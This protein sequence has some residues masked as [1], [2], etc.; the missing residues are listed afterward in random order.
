LDDFRLGFSLGNP[1]LQ[2][3]NRSVKVSR[4]ISLARDLA[5]HKKQIFVA[6]VSVNLYP[7]PVKPERGSERDSL[8][9]RHSVFAG[10]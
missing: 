8:K 3:A 4:R 2:I 1:I 6:G 9:Q 10:K 7:D 5:R